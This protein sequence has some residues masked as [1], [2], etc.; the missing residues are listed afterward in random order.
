MSNHRRQGYWIIWLSLLLGL[1]LQIMPWPEQLYMFRPTWLMLTLIY[2]A[3]ALPHRVSVGSGLILG[4]MWDLIL[5]APLG[6]RGLALS[7]LTYLV[8]FKFQLLR[9]M[10]LWQQAI[11][12][13]LMT[14]VSDLIIFA[15]NFILSH[16]TTPPEL[17]WNSVVNGL[18]WPWFFLL[19]RNIRRRFSI[20]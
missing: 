9:N 7:V 11:I 8:A 16:I 13:M 14:L 1:I 12:I 4:L 19:M 10:A 20:Q 15:L 2:W 18:L 17:L 3:M 6:V 5:G